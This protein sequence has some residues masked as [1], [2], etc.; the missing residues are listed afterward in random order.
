VPTA[1][2]TGQFLRDNFKSVW[3]LELLL[4]LAREPDR[5]FMPGDLVEVLRSS[6][7]IVEKSLTALV[8]AGLIVEEGDG[9]VRYAPASPDLHAVV[10]A[11]RDE[12]ALRPD[13]VRRVIV[14]G[15]ASGA[16]AFADA[17]RLRKD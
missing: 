16:S 8:A 11:V 2:D 12:Y 15:A 7:G 10:E 17:F 4:H 6:Q 5:S 1:I 13:A 14:S 9:S 3:S